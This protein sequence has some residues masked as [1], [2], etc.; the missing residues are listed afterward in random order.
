MPVLSILTSSLFSQ[1]SDWTTIY[2]RPTTSPHTSSSPKGTDSGN[3]PTSILNFVKFSSISWSADSLGFFYQRFP[4]KASHSLA[5]D[6]AGTEVDEDSGA[7]IYYHTIDSKNGQEDDQLIWKDDVNKGWMF[8][9]GSTEDGRYVTLSFS[10][11]TGRSNLLWIAD[12][13]QG[14]IGSDMVWTKVS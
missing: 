9:A 1:G 5:E 2:V 3:L 7:M 4:S 10:R 12:L 13:E 6:A 14:K 11:D 8:G